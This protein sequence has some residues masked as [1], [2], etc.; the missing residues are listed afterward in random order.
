M[1]F[2]SGFEVFREVVNQGSFIGAANALR[3]SAPAVSKQVKSLENRLGL[4]LFYR[5]TRNVTLTDIGKQ[6]F[7]TL[8]SS[9]E[10]MSDLLRLLS[11]QQ[12]QPSGKLRI[13]AP[14]A[15]GEKFLV[16]P[17]LQYAKTYPDVL[18]DAVFDDKRI[19]LVEDGY[20]II[21]RIG[22]L[23]D[24]GSVAKKLSNIK[25]GFFACPSFLKMYSM[26]NSPEDLRSVPAV[27]YRNTSPT[28]NYIDVGGEER[29][30]N[31]SP[32]L[33]A[34]SIAMLV[35]GVL[36]GLGFAGLPMFA[37]EEHAKSGKLIQI[38]KDYTP[39]PDLDVFVIYPDKR[40]LPL[41]VRKFIDLLSKHFST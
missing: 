4:L 1:I 38:L 22:K 8:D 14:M 7:D 29:S 17:I 19:H 28:L 39:H 15:F 9:H 41:K 23:E 36:N 33:Y 11:T 21:I 16:G 12:E 37:A 18:V 35:G 30:M 32:S 26:I 40:F 20:D 13:N 5:T 10:E 34:N 25:H 24:S 2:N 3:I 31:M 27:I 6:L